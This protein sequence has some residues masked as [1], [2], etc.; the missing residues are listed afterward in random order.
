MQV[1]VKEEGGDTS[2]EALNRG[3]LI[4]S[5]TNRSSKAIVPHLGETFV[6][7]QDNAK[8]SIIETQVHPADTVA[9]VH[10]PHI[11]FQPTNL[12]VLRDPARTYQFAVR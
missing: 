1:S 5:V 8:K 10:S 11:T 4:A 7:F 6:A 12:S 2:L 3:Y 9:T